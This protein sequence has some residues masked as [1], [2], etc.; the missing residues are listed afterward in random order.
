MLK[1][2]VIGLGDISYIHVPI[3]LKMKEVQLVAVCDIDAHKNN[4]VPGVPF[5]TSYEEMI[6]QEELDVVH[7]CLPHYLHYSVTKYL[8]EHRIHVLQEKPLALDYKE[9]LKSLQLAQNSAYKIC[10]CLQNR[11]N[12]SV[13][14]LQALLKDNTYGSIIG[15]KGIVAWARSESYYQEKPW[16]ASWACAG[17]GVMIN[18]SIHTLDLMQLFGGNIVSI[19]GSVANLLDYDI[20]VEDTATACITFENGRKGWFVS[21]NANAQNDS[22]QIEVRCEHARF[23]IRDAKLYI[24]KEDDEEK[25]LIEDAVLDGPKSYYGASHELVFKDFYQSIEQHSNAYICVEDSLVSMK[26]IAAIQ[27]SSKLKKTINMEELDY[28]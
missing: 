25:E 28:A 7:V 23:T 21:T 10:I 1:I 27:A 18:Q 12:A 8:V 3:I 22:V 16:R 6:D 14:T 4:Q 20:E 19:K 5:Y 26:M 24:Q 15:I 11:R 13:Q 2:G 9:G 17:G